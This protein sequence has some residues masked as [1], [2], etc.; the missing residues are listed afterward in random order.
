M[1]SEILVGHVLLQDFLLEA[2]QILRVLLNCLVHVSVDHVASEIVRVVARLLLRLIIVESALLGSIL[3]AIFAEGLSYIELVG[4]IFLARQVVQFVELREDE[5]FA[6]VCSAAGGQ[7][8]GR[9]FLFLTVF[10]VLWDQILNEEAL[11]A[12]EDHVLYLLHYWPRLV[13]QPP[14]VHIESVV[15][16]KLVLQIWKACIKDRELVIGSRR[17]LPLDSLCVDRASV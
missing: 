6:R 4:V 14:N 11:L 7:A 5:V 15:L 2:A 8:E 1:L 17:A 9:C 10:E 3:F 13:H 16:R 12:L